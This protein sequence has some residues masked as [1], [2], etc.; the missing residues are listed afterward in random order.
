MTVDG[1]P[2]LDQVLERY[3]SSVR[4]TNKQNV[5]CP[6]HDDRTPSLSVNLEK[7]VGHCHSC[8]FAGNSWTLIMKMEACQFNDAREWA[9][10]NL[11]FTAEVSRPS[12]EIVSGTAYGGRRTIS[13][14]K[15][16]QP[17][18]HRWKPSWLRK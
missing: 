1:T 6:L 2:P 4:G 16:P 8:G 9:E 18:K 12:S 15:G 7:N 17:A 14:G 11:G 13:K 3:G 10:A 5:S